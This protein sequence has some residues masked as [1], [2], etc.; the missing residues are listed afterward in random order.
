MIVFFIT[1]R[2]SYRLTKMT[3]QLH[4]L[5]KTSFVSVSNNDN[6]DDDDNDDDHHHHLHKP[7]KVKGKCKAIPLKARTGPEGSRRLRFPDF[8]TIGT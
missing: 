2:Y 1:L 3:T 7:L 4:A 8:K 6:D 5:G